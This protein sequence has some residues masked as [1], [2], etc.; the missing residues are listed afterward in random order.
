M[1]KYPQHIVAVDAVCMAS[2][3]PLAQG[4][5][6]VGLQEFCEKAASFVTIREREWLEKDP[7]YRQLLP[8]VIVTQSTPTGVRYITYRRGKGVGES[9]LAGNVSVGF[10]GHIDLADVVF[11]KKTSV[12]QLMETIGYAATREIAEELVFLDGVEEKN[13]DLFDVGLIVD[14]S[15]DVGCVH[16]GLALTAMIPAD[17][18]VESREEE[19]EMLAPMTAREL[20]DSGLPLE[21]WTRIFLEHV[22]SQPEAL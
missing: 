5:N 10:G 1:K 6:R 13:F 14:N 4:L 2:K 11:D 19:L 22:V 7:A 3:P 12:I 8:Y 16:L 21:N 17:V 15:N 18:V 9:R 20:L